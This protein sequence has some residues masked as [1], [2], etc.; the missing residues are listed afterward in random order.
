MRSELITFPGRDEVN[1][2]RPRCRRGGAVQEAGI[3][4][5]RKE[6]D[7]AE[8]YVPFSWYEPM[9]ME[10]LGFAPKNE[11]WKMTAKGLQAST[12]ICRSTPPA[13]SSPRTRSALPA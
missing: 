9:W 5:P 1:R 4:D 11:G 12:A 2:A 7:I 10:N 8:V 6:I 13:A 3:T